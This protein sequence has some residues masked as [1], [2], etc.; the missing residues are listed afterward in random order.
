MTPVT[1]IFSAIYRGYNLITP[2]TTIAGGPSCAQ[3]NYHSTRHLWCFDHWFQKPGI[4]Y[5]SL[6]VF[7]VGCFVEVSTII[8]TGSG[9]YTLLCIYIYVNMHN[10]HI[11]IYLC[12]IRT[13]I[14]IYIVYIYIDMYTASVLLPCVF[15]LSSAMYL[16]FLQ[17]H[18]LQRNPVEKTPPTLHDSRA[19]S[20]ACRAWW[21]GRSRQRCRRLVIK[22]GVTW[23]PKKNGRKW[24]KING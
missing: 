15:S 4:S 22:E 17:K 3:Q 12:S 18:I 8:F 13:C 7:S 9:R 2:F 19:S 10:I 24:P 20:I 14:Y 1:H 6:H 23:D 16:E 21:W 11:C 5:S